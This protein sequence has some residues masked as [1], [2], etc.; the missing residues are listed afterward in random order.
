MTTTLYAAGATLVAVF[1]WFN[2]GNLP[3][4]TPELTDYRSRF[5]SIEEDCVLLARLHDT[6]FKGSPE[7]VERCNQLISALTEQLT[8]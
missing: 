6:T 1:A 8:K 7:S 3:K 5:N 2:R 4:P